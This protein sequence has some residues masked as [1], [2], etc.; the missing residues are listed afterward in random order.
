MTCRRAKNPDVGVLGACHEPLHAMLSGRHDDVEELF[1]RAE[2]GIAGTAF[3]WDRAVLQ[4]NWTTYRL[5]HGDIDGARARGR[6]AVAAARAAGGDYARAFSLVLC[7]D[8]DESGGFR[9]RARAHWTEA[10]H[11]LRPIGARALHAYSTLRI[12]CLDIGEGAIATAEHRLAEVARLADELGADDLRAAAAILRGALALHGDRFQE[13]R[14][15][16]AVSGTAPRHRS[17]AGRCPPSAWRSSR[18]S[19]RPP[20][21]RP[22]TH[23]C[24]GTARP[25]RTTGC[26][27]RWAAARSAPCST[28][29]TPVSGPARPTGSGRTGYKPGSPTTPPYRPASA[30]C[31]PDRAGI[32]D[33][34]AAHGFP[35]V[36]SSPQALP[37]RARTIDD[38]GA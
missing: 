8:A 15:I 37:R 4:T 30:E 10:V 27:S 33:P 32:A 36:M 34:D 17:T 14:A 9:D 19:A 28:P 22:T 3:H 35:Q 23:G 1:E 6:T 2:N 12:V 16:F 21:R 5:Q 26:A 24:G 20:R 11:L 31:R 25:R 7:G 29:W 18:R 38:V 13:A